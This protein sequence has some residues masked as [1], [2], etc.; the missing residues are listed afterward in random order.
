MPER[1]DLQMKFL[2]EHS[3]RRGKENQRH[4][5]L[6]VSLTVLRSRASPTFSPN[7][8]NP[9]QTTY[10]ILLHTAPRRVPPK[11]HVIKG[12]FFGDGFVDGFEGHFGNSSFHTYSAHNS[13]NICVKYGIDDAIR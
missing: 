9:N 5:H 12:S 6:R 3:D 1:P 13:H 8:A 7:Y 4:R 11:C 2:I 10:I